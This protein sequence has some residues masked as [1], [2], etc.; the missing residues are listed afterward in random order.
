LQFA[1]TDITFLQ[2]SET[3]SDHYDLSQGTE[4]ALPMTFAGNL[5]T[6]RCILS[7]PMDLHY[8]SSLFQ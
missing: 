7:N 8:I 1:K 3:S 2:L 5:S 6:L 4:S